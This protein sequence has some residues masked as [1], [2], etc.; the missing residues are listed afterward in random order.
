MALQTNIPSFVQRDPDAIMAEIKTQMEDLLGRELQP[1]QV[2]QLILQIIGFR[3]VLLLERFNAGMAQLL[4]QFSTAPMLDYVAALLAVERL[5]AANA[6]CMVEFTLV[7]GHGSV[8]IPI[9]T[10]VATA[11]GQVIFATVDDLIIAPE[12]MTVEMMVTAQD[13]GKA[14]NGHPPGTVTKI[15]D[16]YAF[17]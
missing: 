13:P 11:N 4:Y 15:L 9:G 17:V 1:G 5:T 12:E 10:R 6:G 7:P 3:E 16:P 14:G 2:E 8:V